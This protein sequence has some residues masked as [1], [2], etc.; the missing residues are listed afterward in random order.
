MEQTPIKR[1]FPTVKKVAVSAPLS[2]KIGGEKDRLWKKGKGE[3]FFSLLV[4]ETS[5]SFPFF[6]CAPHHGNGCEGRRLNFKKY[7]SSPSLF[8]YAVTLIRTKDKP[9]KKDLFGTRKS[10]RTKSSLLS[11]RHVFAPFVKF[12]ALEKR[13]SPRLVPAHF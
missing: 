8:R 9:A 2:Q 12:F 10:F 4:W 7:P 13:C 11:R 6:F 5:H 1:G 3:G